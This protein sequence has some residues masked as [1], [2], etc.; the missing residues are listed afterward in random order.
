MKIKKIKTEDRK[1]LYTTDPIKWTVDDHGSL[2]LTRNKETLT[3][4]V[5]KNGIN[6]SYKNERNPDKMSFNNMKIPG[7]IPL[8]R[9]VKFISKQMSVPFYN[10]KPSDIKVFEKPIELVEYA[11]REQKLT[12]LTAL[13]QS[14]IWE[15]RGFSEQEKRAPKEYWKIIPFDIIDRYNGNEGPKIMWKNMLLSQRFGKDIDKDKQTEGNIIDDAIFQ[16]AIELKIVPEVPWGIRKWSNF[17]LENL[18]EYIHAGTTR[19]KHWANYATTCFMFD[20]TMRNHNVLNQGYREGSPLQKKRDEFLEFLYKWPK[21]KAGI[22]SME[23]AFN[24]GMDMMNIL[25]IQPKNPKELLDCLQ[26]W[27]QMREGNRLHL[28]ETYEVPKI[29][30]KDGYKYVDHTDARQIS[31]DYSC[32]FSNDSQYINTMCRGEGF[33]IY[34]PYFKGSDKGSL[35]FFELKENLKTQKQTWFINE[36][37]GHGNSTP[38]KEY[39]KDMKVILRTMNITQPYPFPEVEQDNEQVDKNLI[40]INPKFGK[41]IKIRKNDNS[42]IAREIYEYSAFK[43]VEDLVSTAGYNINLETYEWEPTTEAYRQELV[44]FNDIAQ[45]LMDGGN[46]V[47][48]EKIDE[49]ENYKISVRENRC[50]NKN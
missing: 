23:E 6:S 2:I 24:Q 8:D 36:H 27:R 40:E 13:R 9:F 37:R 45:K 44:Q 50:M 25:D 5:S 3:I 12:I 42:H 10:Q 16:K 31:D 43:S 11:L 48:Q 41:I 14:K 20:K 30:L 15:K 26:I 18:T 49:I 46:E 28:N 39:I 34:R 38:D 32:C 19:S 22:G 17:E 35:C 47:N 21:T 1:K 33:A 4:T 29:P 7:E